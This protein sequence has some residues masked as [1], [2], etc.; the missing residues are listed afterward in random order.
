MNDGTKFQR[1][2]LIFLCTPCE[3]HFVNF[4][5]AKINFSKDAGDR[6]VYGMRVFRRVRKISESDI[7]FVISVCPSLSLSAWDISAPI[8]QIFMKFYI[9]VFFEN[10]LRKFVSLKS[11]KNN[12]CFT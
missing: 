8:E 6:K 12:G 5:S 10:L 4:H 7:S 1:A 11:E 9:C 3:T 2:L